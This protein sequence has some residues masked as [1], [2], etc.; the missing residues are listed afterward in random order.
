MILDLD[1][2]QLRNFSLIIASSFLFFCNFSSFFLLPLF[3]KSLGGNERNIGFVMGS[4]GITSIGSIPLVSYLL[5]KYGRRKFLMLG[6]LVMSFSSFGFLFIK[7]LSPL[8]YVFRLFQGIGFAFFFHFV[9]HSGSRCDTRI[10][11]G[12][13]VSEYLGR[14]LF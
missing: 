11:K 4:F 12:V 1:R 7:D 5:D 8:L 3:I 6:S 10:K 2:N 9:S 13:R 14:F